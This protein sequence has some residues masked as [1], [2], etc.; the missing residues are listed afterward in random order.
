MKKLPSILIIIM[1]L[2]SLG[3][4]YAA[5]GDTIWSKVYN[6]YDNDPYGIAVDSQNNI[7]VT[8]GY[9]TIKY[10]PNGN[11]LWP[12]SVLFYGYDVAVDSNNNI[13]LTNDS[14]TMKYD[15]N[16]NP[17][18]ASAISFG[19]EA[20]AVDSNNNI[21]VTDGSD[22]MKYNP[23]GN[24]LWSSAISFGGEATD[25]SIDSKNNI[26]VV[27]TSSGDY[28]I[29]KHDANGNL[30]WDK[31]ISLT[32]GSDYCYGVAVDSFDNIIV[33]GWVYDE[34]DSEIQYASGTI[35][36]TSGGTELWR[37]QDNTGDRWS[38]KV[39]IDSY[40]NIIITGGK[41]D[42]Y[43]HCQF[44]TVKYDSNGKKIWERAVDYSNEYDDSLDVAVDSQNNV[45]VTGYV[46]NGSEDNY[47]TIKYQGVPPRRKSLP[48]AQILKILGLNLEKT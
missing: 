34:L 16:G 31:S 3:A 4:V 21:I 38:Y 13:I 9:G 35:K 2:A 39:A 45:I 17:L 28:Y 12:S 14:A 6:S 43:D 47:Y 25:V 5:D 19:G 10:D 42:P 36:F 37:I 24:E 8:G 11:E 33:T 20:V 23:N 1:F 32:S 41:I 22:A 27:G 26:I 46:Y 7:I 29:K 30:L 44:L 15:P 40:N 18:W 48:I